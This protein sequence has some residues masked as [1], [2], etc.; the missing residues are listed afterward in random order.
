MLGWQIFIS[1]AYPK[2]ANAQTVRDAQIASWMV[3]LY[4]LSWID[5]LVVAGKATFLGGNGYPARYQI[6]AGMLAGA[7]ASGVPAHESPPVI[8]DDY[9]LPRNW[10]GK[11][12]I[13]LERLAS[14]DPDEPLVVEAW[15]QS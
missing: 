5:D 6:S 4:G 13:D 11:V 12:N 2:G 9:V 10:T 1:R 3:G 14:L 7:L 15:D 8:G